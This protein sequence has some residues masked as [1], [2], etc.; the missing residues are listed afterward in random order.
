MEN[1]F[2]SGGVL[3][4]LLICCCTCVWFSWTQN[5]KKKKRQQEARRKQNAAQSQTQYP[6]VQLGN[7]Q[8]LKSASVVSSP[9]TTV[10]SPQMFAN[11]NGIP[12]AIAN[13]GIGV[14]NNTM[15]PVMF[16]NTNSTLATTVNQV[17]NTHQVGEMQA[18]Q[19]QAQQM[20][21]QQQ[22]QYLAQLRQ[23]MQLQ[24]MQQFQQTQRL[25]QM[26]QFSQMQQNNNYNGNSNN[27]NNNGAMVLPQQPALP[28]NVTP[29]EPLPM[30]RIVSNEGELNKVDS[31]FKEN[32][33]LHVNQMQMKSLAV[34]AAA[35]I[36]QF[37]ISQMEENVM[38]QIQDGDKVANAQPMHMG[39]GEGGDNGTHVLY[40]DDDGNRDTGD[41]EFEND[42]K[43]DNEVVYSQ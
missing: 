16:N 32:E 30:S 34:G 19:M 39:T 27:N 7:M 15:N 18:Q 17:N 21:T 31:K 28:A 5:L 37:S 35:G 6:N 11:S 23:Q 43:S 12:F 26:Q 14:T 3:V 33:D 25:Q 41:H 24:Q 22:M 13:N 1:L 38:A 8:S 20:Q 9:P 29:M 2:I 4:L 40:D 42:A 10:T 36:K